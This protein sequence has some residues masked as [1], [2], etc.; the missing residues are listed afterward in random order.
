M[1]VISP[2]AAFELPVVDL[3]E[4]PEAER[5]TRSR[6]IIAEESQRPFD[7]SAGPLFRAVLV[8]LSQEE[9]ILVVVMHHIITDGW[10]LGVFTREL[11]A[12][13]AAFSE[14]KPSP[15]PDLPV[16]YADYAA[17]QRERLQGEVLEG[18]L[19]YWKKKLGGELP[20]AAAAHGPAAAGGAD[21]TGGHNMSL[22]C[23]RGLRRR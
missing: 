18:Q 13:Y 3:Q 17:W 20:H 23:P 2:E 7:L 5:E 4:L 10:S 22:I 11:E 1:Q 14:G 9:H 12:L 21:L 15:L 6:Q 16:Q 8:Q 19:A